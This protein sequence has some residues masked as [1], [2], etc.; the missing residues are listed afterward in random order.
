MRARAV[1]M[2]IVKAAPALTLAL[3][4]PQAA[5]ALGV[6]ETAFDDL[7][8]RG[9]MPK[10]YRVGRMSLWDADELRTAWEEMKS[11]LRQE[12]DSSDDWDDVA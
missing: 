2:P 12:S 3:R 4:R 9:L 6:S 1:V 11:R 5:G 10:P 8:S 7:V